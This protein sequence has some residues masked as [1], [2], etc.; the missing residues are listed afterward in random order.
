MLT[1][2]TAPG[3]TS[4]NLGSKP[5]SVGVR[6]LSESDNGTKN[7]LATLLLS[8]EGAFSDPQ[9]RRQFERHE[10]C[11]GPIQDGTI[12]HRGKGFEGVTW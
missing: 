8:L 4:R 2:W 11:S 6:I 9:R 12:G 7:R 1:I 10:A 5:I 3:P